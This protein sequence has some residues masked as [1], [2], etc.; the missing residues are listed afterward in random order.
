MDRLQAYQEAMYFSS[1]SARGFHRS[2]IDSDFAMHGRRSWRAEFDG[3]KRGHADEIA[4]VEDILAGVRENYTRL[5]ELR[6]GLVDED[7]SG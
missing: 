1:S 2:R 4:N 3:W 7:R 6:A 5:A